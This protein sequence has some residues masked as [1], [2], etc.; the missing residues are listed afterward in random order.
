MWGGEL[1]WATEAKL[2][3]SSP[4][5]VGMNLPSFKRRGRLSH[6]FSFLQLWGNQRKKSLTQDLFLRRL[7]GKRW[8]GR[9][10][11]RGG[12]LTIFKIIFEIIY[13]VSHG[14]WALNGA[15]AP[16]SCHFSPRHREKCPGC[17]L[18][19]PPTLEQCTGTFQWSQEL[20]HNYVPLAV[21]RTSEAVSSR[22][23]L[24]AQGTVEGC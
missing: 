10:G 8:E 13:K 22:W 1:L 11:G 7:L 9:E 17:T 18:S 3:V 2:P 14:K 15:G 16:W 21:S 19:P 23:L 20:N 12:L 24:E 4:W 6:H 5:P